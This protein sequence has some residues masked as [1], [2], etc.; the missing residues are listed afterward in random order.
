MPIGGADLLH[1]SVRG[2]MRLAALGDSP[3]DKPVVT[4]LRGTRVRRLAAPSSLMGSI[5]RQGTR[6]AG[7]RQEQGIPGAP[8]HE[9]APKRGL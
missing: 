9:I 3:S 8:M 4:T 1:W 6:C 2:L 5:T 7:S